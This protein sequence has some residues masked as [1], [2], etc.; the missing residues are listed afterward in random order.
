MTARHSPA[1][2]RN[3]APIEAVLRRWLPSQ[4]RVLELAAG[5]GQHALRFA[6]AFP[7]LDW[8]PSDP[9]PDARASIEALRVEASLAN[10]RPALA[11]DACD[12]SWPGAPL[13]AVLAINMIHISPWTSAL[14]LLDG[15][16]RELAP[17]GTLFLYGPYRVD[18]VP[19]APSNE[20]FDASLRRRDP[21][22]GL[23]RLE[24]VEAEAAARGLRRVELVQMP[25]NNLSVVFRRA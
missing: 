23:R 1:A 25:A 5:T 14:G 10:L 9:D 2:A 24:Q 16:A 8:Q 18:G 13:D 15:A 19:T 4:G 12:P 11:V 17:G 6:A 21:A 22:W 7:G 20:A 3:G